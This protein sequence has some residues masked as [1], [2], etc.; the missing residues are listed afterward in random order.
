MLL[1][2]VCCSQYTTM[3]GKT[4]IQVYDSVTLLFQY[5]LQMKVLS[6]DVHL[7]NDAFLIGKRLNHHYIF[8]DLRQQQCAGN[9][10]EGLYL[11]FYVV[12]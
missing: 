9:F 11:V 3:S 12:L 10:Y 7:I 6:I 4:F 2:I 1:N 5:I 8:H